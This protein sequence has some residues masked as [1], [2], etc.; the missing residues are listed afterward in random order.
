MKAHT[1][2]PWENIG[3]KKASHIFA[4]GKQIARVP[5]MSH[6]EGA[7]ARLIAASPDLLAALKAMVAAFDATGERLYSLTGGPTSRE[8]A[9]T[10]IAKADGL[11]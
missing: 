11:A 6:E 8:L 1:P 10:A 7:N 4:G 9:D 5:V 3:T 2:G